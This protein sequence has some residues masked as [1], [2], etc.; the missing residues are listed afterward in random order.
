[1]ATIEV[2]AGDGIRLIANERQRQIE[3]EGWTVQHDDGHDGGELAEAAACYALGRAKVYEQLNSSRG[4]DEVCYQYEYGWIGDGEV[5]WPWDSE[6]WKP[7]SNPVKNLVRAGALI[8]AEID[9]LMRKP[10]ADRRNKE[11]D[12]A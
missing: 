9:R 1:M 12:H 2:K 4:C 6:W 8:A 5:E 11:R 3:Q 7:S 10:E